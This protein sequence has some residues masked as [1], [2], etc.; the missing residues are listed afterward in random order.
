MDNILIIEDGSTL[1][2]NLVHIWD[3]DRCFWDTF[4]KGLDSNITEVQWIKSTHIT[5]NS[6]E[7]KTLF[8]LRYG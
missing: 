4:I 5:F 7:S 2:D 3:S 1:D 8:L 6:P